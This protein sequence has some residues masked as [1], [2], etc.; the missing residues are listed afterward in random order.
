MKEEEEHPEPV[1]V[2]LP[3][4]ESLGLPLPVLETEGVLLVVMEVV[5][6][7]VTELVKHRVGDGDTEYVAEG[8][9][10][11]VP[12]METVPEAVR[13]PLLVLVPDLVNEP[14]PVVVLDGVM[15]EV[16]H[17]EGVGDMENDPE[18][19]VDLEAVVQW[20]VEAVRHPLLDW[21]REVV[22]VTEMLGVM[23]G[24]GVAVKHRLGELDREGEPEEV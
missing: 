22:K 4:F 7:K 8:L 20:V 1:D 10:D 11:T 21:V 9:T 3:L 17:R 6:E 13:H 24:L 16:R 23:E 18:G 14:V 2:M 5:G 19:L 12:V 15:V